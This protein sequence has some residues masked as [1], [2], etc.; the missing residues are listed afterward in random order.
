MWADTPKWSNKEESN[1]ECLDATPKIKN[2]VEAVMKTHGVDNSPNSGIE[3]PSAID[4]SKGE[5]FEVINIMDNSA[6]SKP[7]GITERTQKKMRGAN[8][9][10]SLMKKM[11]QYQPLALVLPKRKV[12]AVTP[13]PTAEYVRA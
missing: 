11:L 2:V 5:C 10:G 9:P 4:R 1:K 8:I 7:V 13:R 3:G 6:P 12:C